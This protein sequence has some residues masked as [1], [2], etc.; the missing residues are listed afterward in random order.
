MI[1]LMVCHLHILA[2]LLTVV[3]SAHVAGVAAAN[4]ADPVRVLIWDERQEDQKKAYGE[5]FLG[6]AIAE[7][8]KKEGFLVRSSGLDD[9]AQGHPVCRGNER[10]KSPGC[11]RPLEEPQLGLG[12]DSSSHPLLSTEERRTANATN[13]DQRNR[14]RQS[15]DQTFFT[16]LLFSQICRSW[17]AE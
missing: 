11:D 13:R 8:F 14:W 15:A 3:A 7:A 5:K 17:Y 10:Q 2:L 6:Q 4:D 9:A 16:E 1:A 12:R